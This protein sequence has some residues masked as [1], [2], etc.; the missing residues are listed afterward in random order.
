MMNCQ[1]MNQLL[2]KAAQAR[3]DLEIRRAIA[4]ITDGIRQNIESLA[5]L[6]DAQIFFT[7]LEKFLRDVDRE[8]AKANKAGQDC[9]DAELK[10]LKVFIQ[11]APKLFSGLM[12]VKHENARAQFASA[13]QWAMHFSIVRLLLTAFFIALSLGVICLK[14]DEFNW[15]L[16]SAA[17][18]VWLL[19][20]WFLSYLTGATCKKAKEQKEIAKLIPGIGPPA[21]APEWSSEDER[22]IKRPL[23]LFSG[24]T[25]LFTGL[26]Y[27]WATHLPEKKIAFT[28]LVE[29]TPSDSL[30][31]KNIAAA[32][33]VTFTPVDLSDV[34][35]SLLLL[36]GD[37]A[38]IESTVSNL[39]TTTPPA[40]PKLDFQP[41]LGE[42]HGVQNAISNLSASAKTPEP[43]D[44][45]PLI[46]GLEKIQTA[47]ANSSAAANGW[48]NTQAA[49]TT[50]LIGEVQKMELSISNSV[51]FL[52]AMMSQ[53]QTRSP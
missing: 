13:G 27:M 50:L 3:T 47:I 44:L 8:H 32:P 28:T 23:Y 46:A 16:G 36:E 42:I 35:S 15:S 34:G 26:C 48:Q 20:W 40:A 18:C 39:S 52:N 22:A 9:L 29:P 51:S 31:I 41:L 24:L 1:D 11:R 30:A 17:I 25:L 53:L 14:W 10:E 38:K 21:E 12:G 45:K 19:A 6:S 4:E 2:G 5:L 7:E 43:P 49:N 33:G 37:L